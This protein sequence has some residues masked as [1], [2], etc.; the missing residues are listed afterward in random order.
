MSDRSPRFRPVL[1]QFNPYKPGKRVANPAGQSFKLASNECP[2]GPLPS[3]AEAIAAGAA[4][5]N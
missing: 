3:V 5:I 2:F 1:K 4:E